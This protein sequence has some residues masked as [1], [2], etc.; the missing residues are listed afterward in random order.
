MRSLGCECYRDAHKEDGSE[1]DWKPLDGD[2][3][4]GRQPARSTERHPKVATN[5]GHRD[6]GGQT[7]PLAGG[8]LRLRTRGAAWRK[9]LPYLRAARRRFAACAVRPERMDV[10]AGKR[11]HVYGRRHGAADGRRS[12]RRFHADRSI[13]VRC[14]RSCSASATSPSTP[15][16]CAPSTASTRFWCSPDRRRRQ[17]FSPRASSAPDGRSHACC[18]RCRA[19]RRR[20]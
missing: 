19:R 1:P 7:F 11:R 5:R 14:G 9:E 15:T 16:W 6:G 4:S 3:G 18:G 13:C 20:S 12:S 17:T 8:Q 2:A 10:P